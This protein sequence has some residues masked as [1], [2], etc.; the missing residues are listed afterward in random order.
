MTAPPDPPELD[1][2]ALVAAIAGHGDRAAFAELFGRFAG[3]VKGFLIR[4]GLTHELA[5]EIA[6]EVLVTVW[7]KSA[8]FDP[9]R[10]SVSTWI[11]T[12]ARNRRIDHLRRQARAEPDPDDPLFQPDPEATPEE[13][14][15][16]A[17]RDGRLREALAALPSDQM[18]VVR[19]SFYAGLSHG[20]IAEQLGLPLGTI[21]SRLRL[22]FNRLRAELGTGFVA[23]LIDE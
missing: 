1:D 18:D 21:K 16:A 2:A 5:E 20:E 23:E 12:I 11:F 8:L 4:G 19:L 3:R 14:A 22:S 7:R 13:E 17:S 6:Q 10:A 15:A 9:A